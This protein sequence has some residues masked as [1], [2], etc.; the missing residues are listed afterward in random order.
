M[1]V[2][3]VAAALAVVWVCAAMPSH[4]QQP[5]DG[6]WKVSAAPQEN[7]NAR[8]KGR[9]ASL[10]V[11]EGKVSY[12]GLLSGLASGRVNPGGD[13]TAQIAKIQVSGK[14]SLRSGSGIWRSPH[15]RTRLPIPRHRGRFLPP[16]R[17]QFLPLCLALL[18]LSLTL[19]ATAA[20]PS[21]SS[22][23]GSG[24]RDAS[25]EDLAALSAPKMPG[26]DA[27]RSDMSAPGMWVVPS[28]CASAR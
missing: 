23:L 11:Q 27:P 22:A 13:V 5:F 19:P 16:S 1:P 20:D 7:G 18:A 21:S 28:T 26:S 25:P 14:L 10:R 6:T 15:W 9:S 12:G 8:C 17:R 4:A 3:R 2:C 24:Y